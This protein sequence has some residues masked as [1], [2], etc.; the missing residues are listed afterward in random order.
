MRRIPEVLD[1]WFDSGSM[2][3]AQRG[4]PRH[5]TNEFKETFPADFIS[6]GLDQTRGWFYTLL[7]ISIL[8][9][10]Q[11]SYRNVICLGHVVD[12]KGKKASKSRGNVLDPN[13][14]FD[15]YGA[16]AVRWYFYT[17]TQVGEN[18]RT[19]DAALKEVVQQFFIPLWNCYSFFV[20]YARLD[21][22][23]PST[24]QVPVA[25]RHVLD[26]WLLSRLAGLVDGGTAGLDHYDANE[27]ARK[28]Q[29]FGYD[30]FNWYVRRSR[31]R[32][33]ICQSG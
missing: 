18:Y 30:L 13:Y 7:A 4:H 11:N 6:E 15:T 3:F 12:P 9:F 27:P 20:T 10:R 5:G 26:R 19:G 32:F 8:L 24:P 31:P 21:E 16:D 28:I 25:E 2:P 22:F 23:D 17:S 33:W 1:T 29:R 14:L